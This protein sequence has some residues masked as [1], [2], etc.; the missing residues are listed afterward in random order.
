[1]NLRADGVESPDLLTLLP[2]DGTT[3]VPEP[4]SLVLF[5]TGAALAAMK[6]RRNLRGAAK[7][8]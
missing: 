4:A 1:M 6:R 3:P 5:G 8:N 7:S 2:Q